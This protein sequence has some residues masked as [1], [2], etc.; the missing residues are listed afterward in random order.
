MNRKPHALLLSPFFH[1]EPISTGRYNTHLVEYLARAGYDVTVACSHP[2]YPSWRPEH[3]DASLPAVQIRRGGAGIRYP[4]QMVLRRAMLE[5]WFAWHALSWLFRLRGQVDVVV[6]VFP[7]SLFA[8][9]A[10]TFTRRPW[11]GI[12]HD[13]QGNF[14]GS[15]GGVVGRLVTA[16]IHRIER[17][18][19]SGCQSLVFLSDTMQRSAVRQYG[20][21]PSRCEVIYPSH[22]VVDADA[23]D[24]ALTSLLP[25]GVRHVVYAGALGHK[26]NPDSLLRLLDALA[27]SRSDLRC[28]VFSA[29]P[30]FDAFRARADRHPLVQLHDLVGESALPTL[31]DRSAVQIINEIPGAG[32]AALPSKL[33]NLLWMAVP[34][35]CICDAGSELADLV[36][37]S[38]VGR[39]DS[40]FALE[41]QVAALS[42][43]VD[44]VADHDRATDKLRLRSAYANLFSMK[45]IPE[46]LDAAHRQEVAFD[47]SQAG[48]C[49]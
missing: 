41:S 19:F 44:E 28:H 27:A 23:P 17:R 47:P 18:A 39:V 35:F 9:I 7:P 37:R 16:V 15:A 14:A 24:A 32:Q 45:R 33:A 10:M 6:A 43:F 48:A 12:V 49:E 2:L 22:N 31:M 30:V 42:A 34:T 25:D 3:S 1:P 36:L 5:L 11:I 29:G 4:A 8:A 21:D 13:L 40:T 38:G 20:L 26:Q 46:L